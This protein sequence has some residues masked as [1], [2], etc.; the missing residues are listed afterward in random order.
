MEAPAT[1]PSI[2]SNPMRWI[3]AVKTTASAIIALLIAFT[4]DLDQPQWALLTV[5]IVAQPQSGLVLA[6]SFYRVIGTLIGAAL[7]LL[8]VALFAQ[9]RVLFLGALAIWIGLC[10]FA[11]Q[12]ARS[13]AAYA[14]VLSGYTTAIVGIPG[15]LDAGNAFFVAVARV[16]EIGLGIIVTATISHLVL[17]MSLA[18]SVLRAIASA[19]NRFADDAVALLN[20]GDNAAQWTKLLGEA[21][22][23][24]DLCASAIFEDRD[25]RDRSE[26]LR[27][28]DVAFVKAVT[29]GQLL[30]WQLGALRP[31]DRSRD[32]SVDETLA[33][34]AVAIRDWRDA[35]IDASRLGER[36]VQ[37]CAPISA[38]EQLWRDESLDDT[39]T[40][41]RIA[42]VARLREFLASFIGYARAYETCASGKKRPSHPVGLASSKDPVDAGWAGVRAAVALVLV[43]IFWIVADWPSGPT[44]VILSAVV[45]ARLATMESS[46]KAAIAGAVVLALAVAPAFTIVEVLL[47]RAQGFE[48]FTLIVAPV[49]FLCAYLM[50]N[51]KSPLAYLAGFLFAL[52]F[53]S[54]GVFRNQM[55][56]DAV[57]FIN[58]SIAVVLSVTVGAVLFALIAPETPQVARSRFTR[59]V[60]QLWAG[61]ADPHRHLQLSEFEMAAVEPLEEF[62]P[63][64][65]DDI[66]IWEMGVALLGVGRDLIRVLTEARFSS[67]QLALGREIAVLARYRNGE[68]L[69]RARKQ[70]QVAAAE[71]LADLRG[72]AL[73]GTAARITC[74][75]IAAFSAID[76]QLHR[77]GALVVREAYGRR[78]RNAA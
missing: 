40:V 36:L 64:E 14:F 63:E 49:L 78:N 54:V 44:A 42:A 77:G 22:S 11:S 31:T 70:A 9:E 25:M 26:A 72:S 6:K 38:A 73:S 51:S 55:T 28:L 29:I 34:A 39:K 53:A 19:R 74:R 41:R 76:D 61:A 12:Y 75:R 58:T 8:L 20:G 7:A 13:F 60:R 71:T 57:V 62:R 16:T 15:T 2:G 1:R 33:E 17:P 68:H 48:M 67:A 32:A 23:I 30:R 4:F 10:T 35:V 46:G 50:G 65:A 18:P 43:S 56:Y 24:K 66:A 69:E 21:R 37:A 47:A 59:A 27:R 52:Y 45:T 3:F 5:F